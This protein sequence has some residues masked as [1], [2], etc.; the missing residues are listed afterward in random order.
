METLSNKEYERLQMNEMET[1]K[2]GLNPTPKSFKGKLIFL[3]IF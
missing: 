1:L 2:E 3:F